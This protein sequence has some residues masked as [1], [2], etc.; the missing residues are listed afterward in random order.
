MHPTPVLPG[1]LFDIDEMDRALEELDER[2]KPTGLYSETF[3]DYSSDRKGQPYPTYLVRA[4][5]E[6]RTDGNC[7]QETER[8]EILVV[9]LYRPKSVKYDEVPLATLLDACDLTQEEVEAALRNRADITDYHMEE[10]AV[11]LL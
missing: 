3:R 9:G 2:P 5:I 4:R 10:A 11:G 6:G 1:E 7:R 8:V